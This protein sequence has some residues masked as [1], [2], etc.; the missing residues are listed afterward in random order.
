MKIVRSSLC[1]HIKL[2]TSTK[3]EPPPLLSIQIF[4]ARVG[5]HY[6]LN[7]KCRGILI[8]DPVIQFINK[9]IQNDIRANRTTE[10]RRYGIKN[11]N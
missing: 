8:Q 1:G 6:K 7:Q 9:D 11:V 4:N 5:Q 2:H 3:D 10:A